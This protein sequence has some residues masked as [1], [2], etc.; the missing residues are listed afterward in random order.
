ML[1]CHTNARGPFHSWHIRGR[2]QNNEL[3]GIDKSKPLSLP[4]AHCGCTGSSSTLPPPRRSVVCSRCTTPVSPT[5][6]SSRHWIMRRARWTRSAMKRALIKRNQ[7]FAFSWIIYR[8]SVVWRH[9][10]ILC[11]R[12]SFRLLQVRLNIYT[13]QLTFG[14]WMCR[15]AAMAWKIT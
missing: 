6:A 13:R 10:G 8:Q 15:C 7:Y 4:R 14:T 1:Y 3:C 5:R 11:F 2:E 9:E 12:L